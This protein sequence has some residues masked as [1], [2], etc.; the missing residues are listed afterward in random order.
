MKVVSTQ[1]M[2]ARPFQNRAS[3]VRGDG[4]F[5]VIAD[6]RSH[7][8]I[9]ARIQTRFF[10]GSRIY[11]GDITDISEKGMFVRTEMRLPVNSR[12]DIMILVDG[13]VISEIRRLCSQPHVIPPRLI[14]NKSVS[15][16]F[17]KQQKSA[18]RVIDDAN[19]LEKQNHN[20]EL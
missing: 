13:K 4:M 11:A 20:A 8:R 14:L 3:K 7:E 17:P 16:H 2:A 6:R 1:K 9:P 10:C 18:I 19:A 15:F 5:N 12:I